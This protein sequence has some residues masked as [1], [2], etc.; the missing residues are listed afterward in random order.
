LPY[1]IEHEDLFTLEP[2]LPNGL[3]ECQLGAIWAL[4]SYRTTQYNISAA[5]I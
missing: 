1:F 5:R 3:R 2:E 4:K